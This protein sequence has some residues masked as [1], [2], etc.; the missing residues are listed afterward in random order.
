MLDRFTLYVPAE[1]ARR[2]RERAQKEGLPLTRLWLKAMERYLSEAA[3]EAAS[4]DDRGRGT[5]SSAAGSES[6]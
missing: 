6:S 1:L 5:T 2:V 4:A 3:S